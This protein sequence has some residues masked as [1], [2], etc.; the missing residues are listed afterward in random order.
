MPDLTCLQQEQQRRYP[1]LHVRRDGDVI[2]VHVPMKLRR[3]QGSMVILPAGPGPVERKPPQ[4]NR[5]LIEAIARAFQWQEQLESGQ[6]ANLDDLARAAGV[7]RSYIGR[8]LRLTSLA[9]D[10]I[11]AILAG[12][13]PDGMSLEKLRKKLPVSWEEQRE[14]WD[15]SRAISSAMLC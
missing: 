3:R 7:D 5:T 13:E 14:T 4:A 12:D 6:Y 9:P 15:F 1:G 10:I 11:E 8:L 2:V